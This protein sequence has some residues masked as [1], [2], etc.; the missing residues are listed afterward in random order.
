M[1]KSDLGIFN[2]QTSLVFPK[3]LAIPLLYSP[4]MF[5]IGTCHGAG[6]VCPDR[7]PGSTMRWRLRP[8]LK[9]ATF[10]GK[11]T[12]DVALAEPTEPITLN[13][14]EIAFQYGQVY[15]GGKQQTAK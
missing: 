15:G 7:A 13:A 11:E 1:T 3:R 2:R 10:A 4:A 12:I 5:S 6:S 14:L 8:D 9:K